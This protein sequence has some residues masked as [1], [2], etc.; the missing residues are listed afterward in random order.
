[1]YSEIYEVMGRLPCA[2]EARDSSPTRLSPPRD[3]ERS[4]TEKYY[5]THNHVLVAPVALPL[6]DDAVSE[7]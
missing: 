2:H 5:N 6:V 1:M 7:P 3:G 4:M